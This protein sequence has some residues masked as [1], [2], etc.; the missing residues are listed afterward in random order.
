[1]TSPLPPD[2]RRELRL[3]VAFAFVA[4][5]VAWVFVD[6]YVMPD[7]YFQSLEPAH[8][9]V[10]GHGVLAW[11]WDAGIRSWAVPYAY[12][13]L[14][15]VA[16]LIGLSG[17][18]DLPRVAQ[19]ANLVLSLL[20]VT[21]SWRLGRIAGRRSALLAGTLAAV[22]APLLFHAPRTLLD[23]GSAAFVIAA[24][25]RL[26]EGAGP[27][28]DASRAG[29]TDD[30]SRATRDGSWLAAGLLLGVAYLFR[31]TAP[32]FFIGP[33]LFLLWHRERRPLLRFMLGLG[34]IV[35]AAGL[36]DWLTWGRPFHSV[37]TYFTFNVAEDGSARYGV[38]PASWYLSILAAQAG[39]LWPLTLVLAALGLSRR[40]ALGACGLG[41]LLGLG[42]MSLVGHKEERFLLPIVVML[43]VA[44]AL[45]AA[46]AAGA[47]ARWD[48]RRR[49]VAASVGLVLSLVMGSSWLAWGGRDWAPNAGWIAAMRWIGERGDARGVLSTAGWAALGGDVVHRRNMPVLTAVRLDEAAAPGGD[50][51]DY[52]V[53]D[54]QALAEAGWRLGASVWG[55]TEVA[56]FR[57]IVV[58]QR[59]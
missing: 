7:E 28:D 42:A 40:R 24:F 27:T 22:F 56:R 20:I 47:L 17:P 46:R 41:L 23:C 43:P 18:G 19:L 51:V 9:A 12:A 53:T 52:L 21:S 49:A 39:P 11:E 10:F 1:M 3:I 30:V 58:L 34:A 2:E 33:G 5:L 25:A 8:H 26:A 4:R 57:E 50:L 45:G 29:A 6:G 38:E 35:I 37:V 13:A 44:F 36:L 55:F 59:P 15:R 48:G 16:D 32:L 54:Q 31:Y 14:F